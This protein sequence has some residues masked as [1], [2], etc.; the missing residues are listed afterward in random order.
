MY[1]GSDFGFELLGSAGV[2]FMTRRAEKHVHGYGRVHE[3]EGSAVGQMATSSA[4]LLPAMLMNAC[5]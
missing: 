2:V 3:A 4:F 1:R 5:P